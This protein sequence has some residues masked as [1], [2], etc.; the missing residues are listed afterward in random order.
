MQSVLIPCSRAVD[1]WICTP[2]QSRY[3][4]HDQDLAS[5]PD[6]MVQLRSAQQW[7][8][9]HPNGVV[10]A[11]HDLAAPIAAHCMGHPSVHAVF[12]TMDKAA[13]REQLDPKPIPFCRLDPGQAMPPQTDF[14]YPALLKPRDGW[15]SQ[16]ITP[17]KT[18]GLAPLEIDAPLTPLWQA[19]LPS[20]SHTQSGWLL[21]QYM[22]HQHI[23]TVDGFVQDGEVQLWGISENLYATSNP[24]LLEGCLFPAQLDDA[25]TQKL[26]S[27]YK[28]VVYPLIEQGFD[29]SFI[30]A[31]FFMTSDQEIILMEINGRL[32][33]IL[34]PLYR[35]TLT[36]G[37]SVEAAIQ[38]AL[39]QQVVRP[40]QPNGVAG[41][42]FIQGQ[43]SPALTQC[44]Q[45]DHL[46]LLSPPPVTGRLGT[47]ILHAQDR[48]QLLRQWRQWQQQHL[49][50]A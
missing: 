19:L 40:K 25:L 15:G 31:E 34:T 37:D 26:E 16:Q 18:P 23:F 11:T 32:P 2:L 45:N 5:M 9:H 4:F 50:L 44:P 17:I 8:Q 7:K 10:L 24:L 1:R 30:N 6:P 22:E 46:L 39:D 14:P 3:H 28:A 13:T 33:I 36:G 29:R 48:H 41:A 38:L 21:E 27:A 20:S 49:I 42:F 43:A 47:L 35:C 12:T